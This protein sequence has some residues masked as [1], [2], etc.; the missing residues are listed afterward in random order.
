M[1]PI[2]QKYLGPACI[3]LGVLILAFG[4]YVSFVR[5]SESQ[6]TVEEADKAKSAADAASRPDP[7]DPMEQPKPYLDLVNETF[8]PA[9]ADADVIPRVANVDWAYNRPQP[10]HID[11]NVQEPT[12]TVLNVP[13]NLIATPSKTNDG[14]NLRWEFSDQV[15]QKNTEHDEVLRFNIE[16]RRSDGGEWE[17]LTE[18]EPSVR[19]YLDT[20][21]GVLAEVI[22]EYRIAVQGRKKGRSEWAY[23][24]SSGTLVSGLQFEFNNIFNFADGKAAVLKITRDAK[25]QIWNGSPYNVRE[26]EEIQVFLQDEN[27]KRGERISLNHTLVKIGE[28][29]ETRYKE[30]EKVEIKDG[31]LV[32]KIAKEPYDVTV[33]FVTIKNMDSGISRD[34]DKTD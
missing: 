8:M 15:N 6:Q 11:V 26:G 14:Y 19:T 5:P 22:Y 1:N 30:V 17:Q 4:V 23:S 2:V 12:I 20:G 9:Y 24:S 33:Q 16:R 10:I 28:R 34:I 32:K 29:N 21:S 25:P 27:G 18:A 31:I 7:V 3:A 13:S